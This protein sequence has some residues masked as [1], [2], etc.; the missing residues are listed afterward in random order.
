MPGGSVVRGV[1]DI[2]QIVFVNQ[3][4]SPFPPPTPYCDTAAEPA[5]AV[6][7]TSPD[8]ELEPVYN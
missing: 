1:F 8:V 2:Q 5:G 6:I 3:V 7:D 4:D